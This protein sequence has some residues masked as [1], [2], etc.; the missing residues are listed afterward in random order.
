MRFPDSVKSLWDDL[1]DRYS[2]GNG[3]RILELKSQIA[4]CKQRGRSVVTYYGEL[5]KLQDELSSYCKLPSCTCSAA[6][7]A[8]YVKMQENE[9]LHQFCIG[10][11]PRKF[12]SV[13][14]ALLMMDPLPSLNVAYAKVVTNERKQTVSEAHESPRP[15]AVGFAGQ[16]S[17]KH[18][19]LAN[20]TSRI[21]SHCGRCGHEKDKCFEL[22]GWPESGRGSGRGARGGRGGASRGSFAGNTSG[23]RQGGSQEVED[24]DRVSAPTNGN[25]F[26]LPS[27]VQHPTPLLLKN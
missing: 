2:L 23:G 6:A 21:C 22:V 20:D 16:A 9:L 5:R 25:N 1:R 14:S 10:L 19:R 17:G 8:A 18:V 13:V 4:D 24:G 26:W 12:G 7:A 11:D 3:P 15:E 27:R